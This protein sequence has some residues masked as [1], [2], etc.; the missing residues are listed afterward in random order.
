MLLGTLV[1]FWLGYELL[2]AIVVGSLLALHTI[3]GSTI[4]ARLGATSLEP[5]VVT[6]GATMVSDTL[7]LLVFAVCVHL[8]ASGFSVSR[9]AIQ[10]IEIV[11]FIPLV[12]LGLGR[13]GS[14]LIRRVEN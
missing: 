5:V 6:I 3:L 2:P 13:A 8:Y 10:V 4:I 12:F 11:V 1:A 7:S 9:I 14:W